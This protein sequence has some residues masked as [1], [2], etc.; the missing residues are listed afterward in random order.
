MADQALQNSTGQ[1]K[2][3]EP[4]GI[5]WNRAE[6]ETELIRE[7]ETSDKTVS[8]GQTLGNRVGLIRECMYV[9]WVGVGENK[10]QTGEEHSKQKD[11]GG[12]SDRW[13]RSG[14][15]S[16]GGCCR[17]WGRSQREHCR[18]WGRCQGGC[19]RFWDWCLGGLNQTLGANPGELQTMG[20]AP[21]EWMQTAEAAPGRWMQTLQ[22]Q[23]A[24]PEG[25]LQARCC[26][27][28]A[29]VTPVGDRRSL[30]PSQ[31]TSIRFNTSRG[32]SA[33]MDQK[34]FVIS[35]GSVS[36][37][38]KLKVSAGSI[39]WWVPSVTLGG[40]RA[41]EPKHRRQAGSRNIKLS[42]LRTSKLTGS[43][44]GKNWGNRKSKTQNV[45]NTKSMT[46]VVI[47]SISDLLP[48][49]CC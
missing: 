41:G 28:G 25:F 23:R 31:Q 29:A 49:Q 30:Q 6:I 34:H 38:W 44:E 36:V 47:F 45:A 24:V 22:T 17:L 27:H 14:G 11:L 37:G 20:A 18:F 7:W 21:T 35:S 3:R 8:R 12:R 43:E 39:M 19:W 15:Q 42:L 10:N 5:N 16:Q 33:W 1:N 32:S 26:R 4:T 48:L 40:I 46:T 2:T 9:M 13:S